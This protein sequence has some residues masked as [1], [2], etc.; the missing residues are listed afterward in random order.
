[1]YM[2]YNKPVELFILKNE[3][4]GILVTDIWLAFLSESFIGFKP[5]SL[6]L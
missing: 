6:G 1:M 5:T 2:N 4:L 3:W